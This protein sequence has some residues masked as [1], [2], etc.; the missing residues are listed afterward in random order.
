MT[1]FRM[2]KNLEKNKF[3]LFI[4]KHLHSLGI[5]W[6]NAADSGSVESKDKYLCL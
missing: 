3:R 1:I 2:S 4:S 5:Y 6:Q